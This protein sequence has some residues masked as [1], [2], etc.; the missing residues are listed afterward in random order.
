MQVPN[1]NDF[2][3]PTKVLHHTTAEENFNQEHRCF[4]EVTCCQVL[5]LLLSHHFY[6]VLRTYGL[7]QA[8][9]AYLATPTV[10]ATVLSSLVLFSHNSH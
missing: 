8:N 5:T 10:T 7:H 3:D 1:S 9:L 6:N 2:G 4:Q